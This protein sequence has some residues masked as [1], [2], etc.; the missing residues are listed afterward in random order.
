MSREVE[1]T[2]RRREFDARLAKIRVRSI[3]KLLTLYYETYVE[4]V[5]S[6]RI[7]W[8]SKRGVKL[9]PG[10]KATMARLGCNKTTAMDYLRALDIMEN[11]MVGPRAEF[12]SRPK[13]RF[14]RPE[15]V[16]SRELRP[17]R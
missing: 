4:P 14:N 17:R 12:L 13:R 9:M 7:H 2:A 8:R 15:D 10:I 5:E 6:R 16:W 3:R 11:L 1:S